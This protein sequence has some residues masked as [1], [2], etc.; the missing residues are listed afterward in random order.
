MNPVTT[1]L[2]DTAAQLVG[3]R[4][5]VDDRLCAVYENLG[6]GRLPLGSG[7]GCLTASE[8][9]ASCPEGYAVRPL[10]DVIRLPRGTP[11]AVPV[12]RD[13]VSA[14]AHVYL[15]RF[16]GLMERGVRIERHRIASVEYMPA[17]ARLR[18]SYDFVA[19][20]VRF[21]EDD[22]MRVH[23]GH[24]EEGYPYPDRHPQSFGAL[25]WIPCEEALAF[26][27]R[28]HAEARADE[29]AGRLRSAADWR[30]NSRGPD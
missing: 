28:E 16:D 17:P 21:G 3:S 15:L 29:I 20:Q 25:G 8:A 11:L 22:G 6:H 9:L 5:H 24:D 23:V 12:D 13:L 10:P 19:V 2:K 1:I 27:A 30:A 4:W 14:S 18:K 7:D 26:I